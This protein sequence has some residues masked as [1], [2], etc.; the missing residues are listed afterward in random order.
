MQAAGGLEARCTQRGAGAS[1]EGE[2]SP[3]GK[4]RERSQ[5]GL[6]SQCARSLRPSSVGFFLEAEVVSE[7]MFQERSNKERAEIALSSHP[8]PTLHTHFPGLVLPGGYPSAEGSGPPSLRRGRGG[9][10]LAE[11]ADLLFVQPALFTLCAGNELFYCLLYLFNFSE[12]PLGR[13]RGA[14][15]ERGR[16]A[17]PAPG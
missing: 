1:R 13:R 2:P 6:W 7:R 5:I 10:T 8:C 15:Q 14:G 16:G 9:T 11:A 12:G 17:W 4:E 3:G